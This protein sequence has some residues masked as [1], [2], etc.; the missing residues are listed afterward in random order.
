MR[1]PAWHRDEIILALD[2]YFAS[3]RGSLDSGNI[4][5]KEVSKLLN[6]LPIFPYRP[7][8]E[9]FRNANG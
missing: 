3:D 5:V 9:R 2:L 8:K 7:D 6:E 4:R 1:N